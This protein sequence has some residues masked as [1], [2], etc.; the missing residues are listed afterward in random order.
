MVSYLVLARKWRPKSFVDLQ[1]QE[2]VTRAL[3][4]ALTHGK[5]HHAYLFT[6][7]RGVGKTTIARILAKSLNCETGITANPCGQCSACIDIDGGRFVD[8][9]E[10]DGA[11]RTRV[12]DTR[13][14]LENVQYAP[15]QGRF[16]IYLIDEVHML[17]NHSFNALLKTL[18]EPPP[19][20]KFI[21]ATT[22]PE[23]IPV[24]VLSRCIR[25]NLKPLSIFDIESQLKVILTAENISFEQ[26]ALTKIAQA[27]SGSMRDALSIVEQAIATSNSD[28]TNLIV[29]EMLGMD[30]ERYMP[31]LLSAI[32]EHDM[33]HCYTLI[34]SIAQTGADFAQVL[35]AILRILHAIAIAQMVPQAANQMATLAEIDSSLLSLK[36]TLSPE[37]VQLLYQIGLMGQ[38]DLPFAPDPRLGFEMTLLR[39]LAFRPS[40]MAINPPAHS[41]KEQE[42]LVPKIRVE[43]APQ[44][45]KIQI[46]SEEKVLLVDQPVKTETQQNPPSF[47]WA[48]IVT[49][50]TL[51]GLSMMLAKS[52][53]VSTW[54]GKHLHLILDNAQKA[55]LNTERQIQIEQ[56][57]SRH[58]GQPI[59]VTIEAGMVASTPFKEAQ[60]VEQARVKQA[61]TALEQNK[62]VQSILSSFDATIEKT[63]ICDE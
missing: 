29:D 44:A 56:A 19:H 14:L 3:I 8:L 36:D 21:L 54:D 16:K 33:P 22:D 50:L 35:K 31:A 15:T 27:A 49:K 62:T 6:G 60:A 1:G 26:G 4:N 42:K 39:M 18:E 55:C 20:V 40:S 48:S 53:I 23:R 32:G 43:Q 58:L 25:F 17:S 7:T 38:K 11:S 37:E 34:E 41:G 51:T 9:I 57:L 45:E 30:F 12:E 28:V 13:D 61:T 5:L 10:V 52:C 47:D 24:T 46:Q 59:K 63:T 2:L